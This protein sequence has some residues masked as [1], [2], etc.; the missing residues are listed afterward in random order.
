MKYVHIIAFV[1][2]IV[3]GLNWAVFAI[4]GWDIGQLF[5][6]MDAMIS[7]IIYILVGV[8]A[9]YLAITHRKACADCLK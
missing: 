1:L 5:G 7:K 8:S 9:L 6:G 3:G 2:V 4:S